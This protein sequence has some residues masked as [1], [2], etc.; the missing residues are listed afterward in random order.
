MDRENAE[1][2]KK[3][4][5]AF[6]EGLSHFHTVLS[7]AR[8]GASPAMLNKYLCKEW[9]LY[10]KLLEVSACGKHSIK[11]SYYLWSYWRPPLVSNL[12]LKL[13][14]TVFSLHVMMLLA[15]VSLLIFS[16]GKSLLSSTCTYM[17]TT[18]LNIPCSRKSLFPWV[19]LSPL[20]TPS[21][22]FIR[23]SF[24]KVGHDLAP[25]KGPE[26]HLVGVGMCLYHQPV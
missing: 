22:S 16:A 4:F 11:A 1:K 21:S 3:L 26:L 17:A 14:S 6:E 12:T 24:S 20:L 10:V 23:P 19:K 15:R 5:L 18:Q 9:I 8:S 7:P 2:D 13:H 25:S